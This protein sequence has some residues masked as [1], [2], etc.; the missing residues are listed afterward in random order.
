M[1]D[2]V[3]LPASAAELTPA[4][5]DEMASK[6]GLVARLDRRAIRDDVLARFSAVRM[7]DAYEALYRQI[8][9]GDRVSRQ[10]SVA[11]AR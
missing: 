5:V 8:L 9:A 3:G 1:L 7:A 6:V 4:D 11:T 10:G 2:E